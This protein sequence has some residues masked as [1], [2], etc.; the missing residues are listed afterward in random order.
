MVLI[1]DVSQFN[2]RWYWVSSADLFA[3]M[4]TLDGDKYRGYIIVS[5]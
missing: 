4:N 1:G 3:G 2:N 5:K